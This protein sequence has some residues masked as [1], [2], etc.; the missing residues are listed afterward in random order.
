MFKKFWSKKTKPEK[1]AAPETPPLE[2][3]SPPPIEEEILSPPDPQAF[4][5]DCQRL[6]SR[7]LGFPAQGLELEW[8][9]EQGLPQSFAQA[10][11]A[12]FKDW[13]AVDAPWDKRTVVYALLDRLLG[14]QLAPWQ[15]LHRLIDDRLAQTALKEKNETPSADFLAQQAR[16]YFVLDQNEKAL[17]L[18]T[19]A[20]KQEPLLKAAQLQQAEIWLW[21][22]EVQKAQPIY[23]RF[24]QELAQGQ[25]Q[26]P[27]EQLFSLAQGGLQ[28]P[29]YAISFLQKSANLKH[30]E[31]YAEEFYWSPHYRMQH[32]LQLIQAEQF[33]YGLSKLLALTKEM[34]WFKQAVLAAHQFIMQTKGYEVF[35]EDMSRLSKLMME[36]DWSY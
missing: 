15:K 4:E 7:Y 31:Q 29:I 26:L 20:L 34:P 33:A 27:F 2:E 10:Y 24:L 8:K 16:L 5:E 19:Q 18:L 12:A 11:P 36:N 21:Q 32:A 3:V 9:A 22:G 28:A 6:I 30:W 13:L 25:Q 17:E 35:A 23:Q 1:A 14:A